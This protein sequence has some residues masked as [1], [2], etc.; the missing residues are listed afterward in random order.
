MF[1]FIQQGS[2]SGTTIREDAVLPRQGPRA[3]AS[4][5]RSSPMIESHQAGTH[6]GT[7][8]ESERKS[9]RDEGGTHFGTHIES[10]FPDTY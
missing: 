9:L 8:F 7:H 4:R 10:R 2:S 6:F 3:P 1:K 5:R